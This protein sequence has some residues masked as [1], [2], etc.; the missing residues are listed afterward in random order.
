MDS[1]KYSQPIFEK[2]AKAIY[3]GAKIVFSA[4]G[5]GMKKKRKANLGLILYTFTHTQNQLKIDHRRKC[6][7]RAK[8]QNY[9]T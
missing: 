5:V 6:K 2:W 7:K 8:S 3:N 4:N 1:H 9:K